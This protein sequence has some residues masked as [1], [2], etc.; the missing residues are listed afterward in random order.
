M[1]AT[2]GKHLTFSL[3]T[4][5]Y[6]LE[7][8]KV[9]EI[10]GYQSITE[11]PQTADYVKGVIN[12]RG[13]VIPVIDLRL[14]FVLPEAEVSDTTCII[15]VE[16]LKADQKK[17]VGII[18]DSVSEVLDISDNMIEPPPEFGGSIDRSLILGM[19][20]AESSIIILLNLDRVLFDRELEELSSNSDIP[21][22][23]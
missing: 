10:I 18:V 22:A 6:G 19:A 21:A 4:E 11:M 2:A 13:M 8:L 1:G 9:R 14:K 15:V 20:K 17:Q 16:A 3:H 7:I 5:E 12:L 23:G